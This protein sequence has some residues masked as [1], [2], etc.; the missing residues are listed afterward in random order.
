MIQT[1]ILH[2]A[3][4]SD[5]LT[6]QDPIGPGLTAEVR[7]AGGNLQVT[8]RVSDTFTAGGLISLVSRKFIAFEKVEKKLFF[9]L[10]LLASQAMNELELS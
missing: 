6:L 1:E 3:V 8:P 9:R 5:R 10:Q 2:T 7:R 4:Q